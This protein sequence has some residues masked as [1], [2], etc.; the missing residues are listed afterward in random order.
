MKTSM[1]TLLVAL[2]AMGLSATAIAMP[3]GEPQTG[4]AQQE[5]QPMQSSEAMQPQAPAQEDVSQEE[6]Q[7]FADAYKEV[8]K[9]RVN[10]ADET[11]STQDPQEM[12]EVQINMQEDM[13]KAVEDAGMDIDTYNKI[14]QMIPYDED[15]RGKIE[16][17]M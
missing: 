16:E 4:A 12:A 13:I 8:E 10:Y 5:Q 14:A 1:K 15:L 9:V 11:E 2:S 3:E 17:L 7:K 6:L